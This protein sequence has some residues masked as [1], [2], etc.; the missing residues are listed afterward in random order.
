VADILPITD[1][2][3]LARAAAEAGRGNLIAFP[4][5]TVYGVGALPTEEG[6]ARIYAAKGRPPTKPVP[7]LLADLERVGEYAVSVPESARDLIRRHWPGPLTL[8]LPGRPE[9]AAALGS[10]DGSI[11]LRAPDH[12][13]LQAL[14]RACGGALAATSANRSGHPEAT[15][16]E[17]ADRALGDHLALV[18]DG[19]VLQGGRASTV[20]D[21]TTHPPRIL[22]PGPLVAALPNDWTPAREG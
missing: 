13:P 17:E 22:R 5:D 15:S 21:L 1:R 6:V 7:L 9:L 18:L 11:G 8:V 19:G 10:R 3:A 14:L 2:G 16:A 12:P 4:T 20:V